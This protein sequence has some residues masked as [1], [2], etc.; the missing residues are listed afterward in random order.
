MAM[1]IK[2]DLSD[3]G[4]AIEIVPLIDIIFC[5][6]I[7]FILAALQLTRQQAI[8]INL[9]GAG[10]ATIQN[11][12]MLMVSVDAIG[13]VYVDQSVVSEAQLYLILEGYQ[14]TNSQGLMVLYADRS[15]VYDD[16][17]RVL[18]L[19]RSVGGNRVALATISPSQTLETEDTPALF[20]L[21]LQSPTGITPSLPLT[22]PN[23]PGSSSNPLAPN[24]PNVP[25]TPNT[26]DLGV[27]NLDPDPGSNP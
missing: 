13:Q 23:A 19:M 9:P 25:S 5:I 12:E 6:L 17:V 22:D 24:L 8:N 14:R 1:K 11:R 27:P 21:D 7:F 18:D 16:V 26:T 4:V 3:S 10:T 15:A 20:P 2:T